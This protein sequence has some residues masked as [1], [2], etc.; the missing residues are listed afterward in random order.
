MRMIPQAFPRSRVSLLFVV[1]NYYAF[2]AENG[3]DRIG[4]ATGDGNRS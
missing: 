4:P 3:Q 2:A 1:R